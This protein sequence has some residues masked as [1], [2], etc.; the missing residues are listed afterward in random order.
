MALLKDSTIPDKNAYTGAQGV[1]FH[2]KPMQNLSAMTDESQDEPY[3]MLN[4]VDR[5]FLMLSIKNQNLSEDS[6]GYHGNNILGSFLFSS[7]PQSRI[8]IQKSFNV[9]TD[10]VAAKENKIYFF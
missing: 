3:Q 6:G 8:Q 9:V 4:I 1:N 2:R 5:I 7:V 10:C